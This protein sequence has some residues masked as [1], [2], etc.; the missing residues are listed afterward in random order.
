MKILF[1]RALVMWRRFRGGA[2]HRH[3]KWNISRQAESLLRRAN[4][5][6]S[7]HE[8]INWITD[9]VEW[10][11]RV[12]E[13]A[14]GNDALRDRLRQQRLRFVLDWLDTHREIKKLVQATA[15][16]T[17]REAAGTE[18]FCAAGMPRESSLVNEWSERIVKR[19]LPRPNSRHDLPALLTTLFPDAADVEW[20]RGLDHATM[21]RLSKLCMDEGIS[22]AWRNQID[23][24]LI[25][26]ATTIASTGISPGFRQRLEAK[27][28]LQAT[29]FMALRREA[30]KYLLLGSDPAA[31]R[32]VRMLIA[33]CQAQ[34][35][36]IVD[37]L[38]EYGVSV[39]LVYSVERMRAQLGRMAQL[40]DLREAPPDLARGMA[41]TMLADLVVGQHR[42]SALQ[43]L[44][45]R[46]FS[47]L[48]R[49]LVERNADHGE[50]YIVRNRGEYRSVLKAAAL[51]GVLASFSVIGM[52]AMKGGQGHFVA[53][54]VASLNFAAS[55][56]LISAVGGVL[57]AKQ[58]V[59]TAPSLAAKMGSLGSRDGLR[60][61][62]QEVACLLRFQSAA[63][64]GNL[65]TLIPT[66]LVIAMLA[67]GLSGVQLMSPEKAHASLQSLSAIGMTPLYAVFIGVLL[68]LSSL[69]AGF[70]DNWFSL[71][72]L[73]S[74]VEHHRRLVH[75]LGSARAARLALWLERHVACFAGN[76]SLAFLLGL[77]PVVLQFLGFPAEVRH[78]AFA[79]GNAIGAMASLGW[80]SLALPETWLAIGGIAVTGLLN[81]G[82]AFGCALMLAL[83]AR[84]VAGRV[85]R[86]VLRTILR[87]FV[88][89]PWAFF[90]PQKQERVLAVV[91]ATRKVSS[92]ER[93]G[94]KSK[95]GS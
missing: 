80:S 90:F 45:H 33:V 88:T 85:R 59:V 69:A 21:A 49:K 4:P 38:D 43:G 15:Q 84:S 83:R 77:G 25:Y 36:R 22:H 19:V 66:I 82:I 47:L 1:L 93:P 17:L 94:N 23:E 62:M 9:V 61:L 29:P 68:W 12:P 51:G 28:P 6:A 81:V 46:S 63:V 44:M 57:G 89:A 48:G 10:L 34:T 3:H 60:G 50:Q 42:R 24:S 27:I 7:W 32:S 56:L 53:G 37:H 65:M 54:L 20:L 78:V 39:N 14:M 2:Q 92:Q 91:A 5:F 8:R 41:Q 35:D 55:F 86:L 74:A 76:L 73:R 26:L 72:Q 75:T 18:L 95:T 71:R 79:A 64:F 31:L 40:I 13:G 67:V 30:E 11:R 16:K 58:A 52:L 70:A 87:R